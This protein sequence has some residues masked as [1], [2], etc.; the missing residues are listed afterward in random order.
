MAEPVSLA[1][2]SAAI[3]EM[4][5]H[6]FHAYS[7]SASDKGQTDELEQALRAHLTFVDNW[8]RQVQIQ[9]MPS[10][11]STQDTIPLRLGT[12]PRRFFAGRG[13][14]KILG[15]DDILRQ[16]LNCAILG[17]PGSGKTTTM[18]RIA[19]KVLCGEALGSEDDV[20]F[21]IVIEC[22]NAR[23]G[24]TNGLLELLASTLGFDPPAQV[25]GSRS[26]AI[27]T[28]AR[29]LDAGPAILLIDGIDEVPIDTRP[30]FINE[31]SD[32]VDHLKSCQIVISCRSSDYSQIVGLNVL[33]LQHLSTEETWMLASHWTTPDEAAAFLDAINKSAAVELTD[34]PLFLAQLLVIF[35]NNCGE[36][37]DQPSALYRIIIDLMLEKWDSDRRVH[38]GSRYKKFLPREK[39]RFLASLA[40][41]M[42]LSSQYRFGHRELMDSYL[43]IASAFRLPG[44]EAWEVASELESHTGIIEESG[45]GFE[46]SHRSMQEY[47]TADHVSRMPIASI[48]DRLLA[49]PAP[50]AIAVAISSDPSAW[51]IALLLEAKGGRRR[52]RDGLDEK[53]FWARLQQERPSFVPSLDLGLIL[54]RFVSWDKTYNLPLL[55]ALGV[56]EA[57]ALAM[58]YYALKTHSSGFN[59][60]A[61]DESCGLPSRYAAPVVEMSPAALQ[62]IGRT[63]GVS[64]KSV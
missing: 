7:K 42:S 25:D 43:R 45:Y 23:W 38:R 27:R 63:T 5:S 50:L 54:L 41:E 2:A 13:A 36:I 62:H 8:A 60:L 10:P 20:S 64:P 1:L 47:L 51:L 40:H 48:H 28:I 22:R 11:R 16:G 12:I 31:L 9:F 61:F 15:E 24:H 3:K 26:E 21:P 59:V 18:K 33:E 34:R 29:Y 39:Q 58:P 44:E 53:V 32:L 52:S 17:E 35:E 55:Q 49:E 57:I 46:F 30:M 14:G 19:S 37:P 56:T 4:V 6:G